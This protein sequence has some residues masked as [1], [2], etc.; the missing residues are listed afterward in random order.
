M[1]HLLIATQNFFFFPTMLSPSITQHYVFGY[2]SLICAQSRAISV[3]TLSSRSVLPVRIHNLVRTWNKRSLES[4]ATFL[5]V[6]QRQLQRLT[7]PTVVPTAFRKGCSCVGVLIPL[8]ST[9]LENSRQELNALDKRE[10]GYD[11]QLVPLPWIHR[12]DD[13]LL[14]QDDN[15]NN[16]GYDRSNNYNK[17]NDLYQGTFLDFTSAAANAASTTAVW[18]YVP[19]VSNPASMEYPIAQ[20]YVDICL[21]GCLDI[22]EAFLQEFVTST[23]GW[24]PQEMVELETVLT[25]ID[26]G[27][28]GNDVDAVVISES[29]SSKGW[30]HRRISSPLFSYTP[31]YNTT[32]MQGNN[33][34]AMDFAGNNNIENH[35]SSQPTT[36]TSSTSES[37]SLQLPDA[38]VDDRSDPIYTRADRTFSLEN[39]ST[40]DDLLLGSMMSTSNDDDDKE[41]SRPQGDVTMTTNS[42]TANV[43]KKSSF[44]WNQL[45]VTKGKQELRSIRRRRKLESSSLGTQFGFY[46]NN[47]TNTNTNK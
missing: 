35:N 15:N 40:L 44:L 39:G 1:T 20:S 3:P 6:Q 14:Y 24:D 32:T 33:G 41:N 4:G 37:S 34:S 11:R 28:D 22:S 17:Y 18:T 36:F 10:V 5:G 38:W 26:A 21:K 29:P 13:L 9:S 8:D 12:V 42:T 27:L 23:V 2:G 47:T 25:N 7:H 31:S 46:N 43:G 30:Y 19:H 45:R 16:N